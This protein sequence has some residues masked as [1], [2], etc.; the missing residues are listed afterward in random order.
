MPLRSA[1]NGKA[2][3]GKHKKGE[4]PA[5]VPPWTPSCALLAQESSARCGE[6]PEALP[7]DSTTFEKVDETFIR[8]SRSEGRSEGSGLSAAGCGAFAFNTFY[9]LAR[10]QL[11]CKSYPPDRLKI[12]L[13]RPILYHRQMRPGNAREA[14]EDLLRQPALPPQRAYCPSYRPVVKLQY[15]PTSFPSDTLSLREMGRKY[16]YDSRHFLRHM[17]RYGHAHMGRCR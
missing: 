16:V 10:A 15:A 5:R 12:R 6:R 7:L 17:L 13:L 3:M 11:Q 2:H 4:P 9:K 8:A 1:A 14:A